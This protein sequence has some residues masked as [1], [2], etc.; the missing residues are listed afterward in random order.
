MDLARNELVYLQPWRTR[1]ALSRR[2]TR[3]ECVKWTPMSPILRPSHMGPWTQLLSPYHICATTARRFASSPAAP[4]RLDLQ[5]IDQKWQKRWAN[6]AGTQ[7]VSQKAAKEKAYILAMF[8]YPSGALHMG[9]LRVYTITDVLARFKHMQGYDVLHPMG[10]DAFGL[11]AE[12]AAI[13][14][15][16]DPAVWTAQNVGKMKEQ[17]KA[18][19]GSMDW[20]RVRE[21]T[22]LPA[23]FGSVHRANDIHASL[24]GIHDL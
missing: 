24:V 6:G 9:H 16:I 3:I 15:G 4:I 7:A 17:L 8:P 12:N 21:E 14:R 22:H 1:Q 23:R 18:M 19:N 11:P 13:E 10:W 2:R 5:A 20:S